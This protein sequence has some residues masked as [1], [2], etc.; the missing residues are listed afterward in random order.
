MLRNINIPNQYG[1]YD[2][3][4]GEIHYNWSHDKLMAFIEGTNEVGIDIF[5]IHRLQNKPFDV[6]FDTMKGFLTDNEQQLI[7]YLGSFIDKMYLFGRIWKVMH[8]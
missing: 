8:R 2:I 7:E 6:F 1:K 3:S 5:N 4:T